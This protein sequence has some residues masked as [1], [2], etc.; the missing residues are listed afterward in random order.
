MGA[1]RIELVT[2]IFLI[3]VAL[4]SLPALAA[5][6]GPSTAPSATQENGDA[7]LTDFQ[8]TP[9]TDNTIT[10]ISV[11]ENGSATWE[12]Q[13]RTRL[14]TEADETDYRAFQEAFRENRTAYLDTFRDSISGIVGNARQVTGREMTATGFSASTSI[15]SIPRKWGIVTFRFQWEGF[16]VV[17]GEQIRAGDVFQS[18]LYIAE[19]DSLEFVAPDEYRIEAA[20]PDPAESSDDVV[21]WI[22][23]EDFDDGR[24]QVTFS[25]AGASTVSG[26]LPWLPLAGGVIVSALLAAG[27]VGYRKQ[28]RD[29]D[30]AT[31]RSP[32]DSNDPAS[33][34]E[35][36]LLADEDYVLE[37]LSSTGGRMKQQEIADE[38]D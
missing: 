14:E 4:T 26:G 34:T 6:S 18:G 25:S 12:L 17:D 36:V 9:E 22:G 20:D 31:V 24:P 7:G 30:P 28:N 19:G 10:R 11:H 1:K 21:T 5:T 2:S 8:A 13:I 37:A 35:D 32:G 33:S 3:A 16:A 38:L 23:R 29:G 27:F 15:Q